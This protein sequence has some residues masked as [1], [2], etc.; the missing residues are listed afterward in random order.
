MPRMTPWSWMWVGRR[1]AAS[2]PGPGAG[3]LR[4]YFYKGI[5]LTAR[6]YPGEVFFWFAHRLSVLPVEPNDTVQWKNTPA[7][8]VVLLLA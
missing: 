5:E 6:F 2:E 3:F 8:A 1:S 4:K 7:R